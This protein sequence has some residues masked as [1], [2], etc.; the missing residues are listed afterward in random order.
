MAAKSTVVSCRNRS[1]L[2]INE[3][4]CENESPPD[5]IPITRLTTRVV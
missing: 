4:L 5:K 2:G 1:N 3:A